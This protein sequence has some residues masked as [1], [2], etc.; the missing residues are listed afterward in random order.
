LNTRWADQ[1]QRE[2]TRLFLKGE[3]RR[4]REA[5]SAADLAA[6]FDWI[7]AEGEALI[8][9]AN[10]PDAH[11]VALFAGRARGLREVLPV[12]VPVENAFVV[13]DGP[14]L[15]PLV[16]ALAEAPAALVVF[17]DA[18]SA[19]LIPVLA[20]GP[21]EEVRL[22][23]DVP[24]HHRRGG[25]AQLAQSRYQR[26]I[27]ERRERHLEAVAET[28]GRLAEEHGVERIVIAGSPAS[29]AALRRALPPRVAG[30]VVGAVAGSRQ[31]PAS[32][33]VARAT[34]MIA[35]IGALESE[36]AVDGLLTD[37]AKGGQAV[38]GLEEAL[39][40]VRR[41]AVD[42]LY[43]LRDFREDGRACVGC[44][45]LQPGPGAACRVCG[46]ATVAIELGEAMVTRTIAAGGAVT[47]VD[48]HAGLA[49]VGGVA[50]R[51]RFA[52]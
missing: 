29:A 46:Q 36:A 24:G 16:A 9:Q 4:S 15:G 34:D 31:E 32:R 49:R 25:W 10:H 8:S 1:H 33:L 12:R 27:Q 51:L 23:S 6:A 20:D 13:A 5:N 52:L 47:I 17:V 40:S 28:L 2:R 45:A 7:Q 22:D 44:A 19:R 48:T 11:S 21:G 43:V 3:L 35:R 30:Q 41:G 18:E 39:E 26:H 42:R 14:F 37:A 38:A 50:A